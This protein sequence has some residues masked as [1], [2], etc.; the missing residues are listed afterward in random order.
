M[1][2]R[3]SLQQV[4]L[5]NLDSHMQKKETGPFSY[6][7][8]KNR[9]KWMK[10]QNVR[11]ESIKILEENR[12]SNL[13]DFDHSNFLIDISPKARETKAQI[14]YWDF[15]KMKSFFTAKET[16][17]KTKRQPEEWEKIF[18]KDVTDKRLVSKIYEELLKLKTQKTNSQVKKWAEN[19]NRCFSK[20]PYKWLI[21]T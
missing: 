18:T 2:K 5:G 10:D 19:M 12:G 3:Q 11:Q 14:N 9:L 1:K 4:V 20:K 21:D 15:I 6:T 13:F 8:H 17:N 16:V 7:I